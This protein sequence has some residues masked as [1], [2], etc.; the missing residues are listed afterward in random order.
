MS[1]K[2]LVTMHLSGVESVV[3]RDPDYPSSWIDEGLGSP[4]IIA[5]TLMSRK[6]KKLDAEQLRDFMVNAVEKGNAHKKLIIFSQ[7][8]VPETVVEEFSNNTTTREYLN[9]GGSVLWLGDSPLYYIGAKGIDKPL[10]AW[11][12][13]VLDIT[14]VFLIPKTSVNFTQ[15]GEE[16]GLRWPWSGIRP[17]IAGRR[18][19]VLAE[20][21]DVLAQYYVNSKGFITKRMGGQQSGSPAAQAIV[22]GIRPMRR[23]LVPGRKSQNGDEDPPVVYGTSVNAWVKNFNDMYPN[24]GFFRIWDFI[25]G[26]FNEFMMRDLLSVVG[27]I[28]KRLQFQG[29]C[30]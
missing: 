3:Y 7:D 1:V 26:P 5:N 2:Q 18:V 23:D 27:S 9:A 4:D 12:D 20:T 14:P 6:C 13:D 28:E 29:R 25:L 19:S 24:C 17:I 30:L 10:E 16:M 15:H 11:R 22:Q 8:V 21:R